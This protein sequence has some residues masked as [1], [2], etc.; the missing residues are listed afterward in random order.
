MASVRAPEDRKKIRV[1]RGVAE[2]LTVVGID[3]KEPQQW[4]TPA[5]Y[6]EAA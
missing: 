4:R 2:Y 3:G 1:Q 5:S 6:P